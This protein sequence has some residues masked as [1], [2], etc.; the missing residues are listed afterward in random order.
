MTGTSGPQASSPLTTVRWVTSVEAQL[1][2]VDMG[3][4]D[5]PLTP[6]GLDSPKG[7]RAVAEAVCEYAIA[8]IGSLLGRFA[9]L[10]GCPP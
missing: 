1:E 7:I 2:P 5:A 8:S 10:P 4:P 9:S 6:S 3:D